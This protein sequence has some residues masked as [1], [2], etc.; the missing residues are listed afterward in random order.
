MTHNIYAKRKV[1]SLT[2]HM[3]QKMQRSYLLFI[4]KISTVQDVTEMYNV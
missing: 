3:L 2:I 4:L 1:T